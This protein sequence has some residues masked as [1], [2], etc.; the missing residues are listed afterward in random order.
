M[1]HV[2]RLAIKRGRISKSFRLINDDK[3]RSGKVHQLVRRPEHSVRSSNSK[4]AY[5]LGRILA[6]IAERSE[7]LKFFLSRPTGWC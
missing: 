4:N 5:L 7:A 6:D 2:I 3:T 1:I